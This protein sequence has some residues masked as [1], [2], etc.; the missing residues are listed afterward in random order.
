MGKN[1][2]ARR[3]DV[4]TDQWEEFAVDEP[5]RLLCWQFKQDELRM[6]DAFLATQANEAASSI[7]DVFIELVSAF[8]NPH[9][10]GYVL[11]EE[12]A[13]GYLASREALR[14]QGVASD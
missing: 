8:S 2:I 10:H 6:A 14:E 4:L 1:P 13:N 9:G 12:L 11:Y 5:A 7:P 3:L